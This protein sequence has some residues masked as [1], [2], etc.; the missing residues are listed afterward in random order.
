[1]EY[2]KLA[3]VYPDLLRLALRSPRLAWHCF[4][5]PCCPAQ[6]RLFGPNQWKGAQKAIESA[7]EKTAYPTKTREVQSL[8]GKKP[9]TGSTIVLVA[10]VGFIVALICY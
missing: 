9:T 2:S 1:M 4:V 3:G 10:A 8:G 6:F 7:A 5:G